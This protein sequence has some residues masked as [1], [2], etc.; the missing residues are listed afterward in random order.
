MATPPRP[1]SRAWRGR[2]SGGQNRPLLRRSSHPMPVLALNPVCPNAVEAADASGL[3]ALAPKC[4][5]HLRS[6]RRGDVV[7]FR[8][9]NRMAAHL[10]GREMRHVAPSWRSTCSR[11]PS[12][13]GGSS[14]L[15]EPRPSQRRRAPERPPPSDRRRV[16]ASPP[17][18][19]PAR[20]LAATHLDPKQ[21]RATFHP[22]Q[23]ISSAE[24]R[25]S[26]PDFVA[27]AGLDA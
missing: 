18:R 10:A 22:C 4:L 17:S 7:V 11:T 2:T 8:V 23:M 14:G 27:R 3:A 15:R 13:F 20:R 21:P 12:P 26:R 16:E 6:S 25:G 1:C 5:E 9:E 24:R 19:G